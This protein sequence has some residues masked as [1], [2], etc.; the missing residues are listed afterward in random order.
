MDNKLMIQCFKSER[1][2]GILF[3]NKYFSGNELSTLKTMHYSQN[4]EDDLRLIYKRC[5]HAIQVAIS[6]MH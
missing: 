4:N 1:I 2:I 3:W 5:Q 6:S